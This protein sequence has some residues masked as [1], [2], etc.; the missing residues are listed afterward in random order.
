MAVQIVPMCCQ[1][2]VLAS[3]LF[4]DAIETDDYWVI[5]CWYSV[6]NLLLSGN[7]KITKFAVQQSL[8]MGGIA[9]FFL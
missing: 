2:G 8:K 1:Q 6:E 4:N 9:V 7:V 3:G 5:T